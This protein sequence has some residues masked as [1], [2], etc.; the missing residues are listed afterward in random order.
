MK[1][2]EN[3]IT[4]ACLE[5][6]ETAANVKI[7]RDNNGLEDGRGVDLFIEIENEEGMTAKYAVETK[8]ILSGSLAE[9]FSYK[10]KTLSQST[11]LKYILLA[12][13][14]SSSV[15]KK[16]KEKGIEFAD[17]F[18]NM[19]INLPWLKV[20][21]MGY[22]KDKW[23]ERQTSLGS[24]T[25]LKIIYTILT[26]PKIT[27]W[28][29]REIAKVAG[30]ALGSVTAVYRELRSQ[31]YLHL[32]DNNGETHRE[33]VHKAQLFDKWITGY[34][35]K[36]RQKIYLGSYRIAGNKPI[37]DLPDMLS[38]TQ[39]EQV[40]I[41]GELGATLLEKGNLRPG[42]ATLH[43]DVNS[44]AKQLSLQLKMIPDVH[45]NIMLLK[46]FGEC[47]GLSGEKYPFP[48]TNPLL[49]YSELLQ[50][51]DPRVREFAEHFFQ[52]RINGVYNQ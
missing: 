3:A 6:L 36:L 32:T 27:G 1:N 11:N 38:N 49:M 46:T 47:N 22:P 48:L 31:G 29:H 25:A 39:Q 7:L 16:F 34:E 17:C 30:V 5:Q 19:F 26:N 4:N 43:L 10:L 52:S 15:A 14:I 45:G 35:D 51:D 44:D 33:V 2:S 24:S 18:G 9:T 8:R 42:S 23:I 37:T 28:T 13:Y 12:E 50:I 20:F 21:I 41:G 40:L